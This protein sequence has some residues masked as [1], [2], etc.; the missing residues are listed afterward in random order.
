MATKTAKKKTTTKAAPAKK[1]A[2]KQ[3]PVGLYRERY[4]E[5]HKATGKYKFFYFLFAF[6]T[7]LFA[8]LAVYF[9]IFSS[10]ILNKYQEIEVCARNNKTCTITIDDDETVEE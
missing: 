8:C 9:F 10:E 2:Q 4:P 3:L 1:T 5:A 7:L 6:T